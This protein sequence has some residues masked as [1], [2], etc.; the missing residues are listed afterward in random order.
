MGFNLIETLLLK[1]F[2][3]LLKIFNLA[4]SIQ[5]QYLIK[6]YLKQSVEI[7]QKIIP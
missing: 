1:R 2:C 3:L 6:F 5:K 4:Q 7:V